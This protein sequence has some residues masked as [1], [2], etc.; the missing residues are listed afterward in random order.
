MSF[1]TDVRNELA[2]VLP[3]RK[4]CQKAELAAL[5][6]LRTKLESG[7]GGSRTLRT[8]AESA[9]TAR[10][11]YTLLKETYGLSSTVSVLEKKR[12]KK[13]R[14]YGV[15]VLL[16]PGE[17]QELLDDLGLNDAAPRKA[18]R[19]ALVNKN[20]CKRAYL[21]G[22][23]INRGFINRPEGAYHLELVFSDTRLPGEVQKLMHRLGLDAKISERKNSLLIYLK[24]SEKIVDFLRL[25]EASHALLA[26]ENVRIVK[27]MRN[28][29][30]RQVNCETANL[31]K[32]VD[33]SVRQVEMIEKLLAKVGLKGLPP[34]LR[35]LA[36]LRI[37]HPD[38]TFK[39]M[40]MLLDPPLTKSGV[41]YRMKK[42]ETLAADLLEL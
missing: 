24:E 5:L 10:K 42:L 13:S 2:R 29:V 26:F 20:C 32:T 22:I 7:A 23:F 37:E 39:E 8:T 16:Q 27:S 34:S 25:V 15:E 9:A 33:A 3:E 41:A 35:E 30:N 21:R 12:F 38:S 1:A 28:Q 40:G 18:I 19:P 6:G 4:C 11:I 36:L 17:G 31:A 14:H